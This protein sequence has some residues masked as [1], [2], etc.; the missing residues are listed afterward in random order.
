LGFK[1]K[2]ITIEIWY[3]TYVQYLTFIHSTC[4]QPMR[5][6]QVTTIVISVGTLWSL[7]KGYTHLLLNGYTCPLFSRK[8]ILPTCLTIFF[9]YVS[10]SFCMFVCHPTSFFEPTHLSET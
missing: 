10:V 5:S 3:N 8:K 4:Q 6:P 2:L 7:L 1:I 9:I